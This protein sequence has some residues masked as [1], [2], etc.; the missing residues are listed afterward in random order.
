[1]KEDKTVLFASVGE[2]TKA[3]RI[4]KLENYANLQGL[5]ISA[6]RKPDDK[7]M[8]SNTIFVEDNDPSDYYF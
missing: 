3:S 6:L 2:I 1:M 8:V 7:Q 5:T 4:F